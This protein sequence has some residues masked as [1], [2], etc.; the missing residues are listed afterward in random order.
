MLLSSIGKFLWGKR[1]NILLNRYFLFGLVGNFSV[2]NALSIWQFRLRNRTAEKSHYQ[3]IERV[4]QADFPKRRFGLQFQLCKVESGEN[5]KGTD[6]S[7]VPL[8]RFAVW[9]ICLLLSTWRRTLGTCLSCR[10]KRRCFS[11]LS[12]SGNPLAWIPTLFQ[13]LELPYQKP[14]MPEL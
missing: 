11:T 14:P 3:G 10:S 6:L 2:R 5:K 9:F 8:Q 4:T 7:P 13:S 1:E 12:S